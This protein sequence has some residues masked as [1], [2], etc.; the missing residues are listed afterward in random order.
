MAQ[1]NI[2]MLETSAIKKRIVLIAKI[3]L[4]P[5]ELLLS[6]VEKIHIERNVT[7]DA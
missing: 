7:I 5:P 2:L 4:E 1:K 6:L 3:L